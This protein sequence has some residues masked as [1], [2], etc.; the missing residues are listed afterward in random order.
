MLTEQACRVFAE[1]RARCRTKKG[2]WERMR[3]MVQTFRL[4]D[5]ETMMA[6]LIDPD[7]VRV[8]IDPRP[9]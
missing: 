7:A 5:W 9:G 4:P 2:L 3:A 1:V 8:D 6:L